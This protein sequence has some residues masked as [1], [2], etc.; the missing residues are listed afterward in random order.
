MDS[1]RVYKGDGV[2]VDQ[3]YI[4]WHGQYHNP[5]S[6]LRLHR[7]QATRPPVLGETLTVN[8]FWLAEAYMIELCSADGHI[9][10]V[11]QRDAWRM[12]KAYLEAHGAVFYGDAIL[13]RPVLPTCDYCEVN[14]R[15]ANSKYCFQCAL[16]IAGE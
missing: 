10:R 3:Q 6:G 4:D 7:G 5:E 12:R 13:K 14:P 15:M 2:L 1:T 9:F 8:N 16:E 11:S